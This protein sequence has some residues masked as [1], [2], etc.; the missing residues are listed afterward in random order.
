MPE[1][2][3]AADLAWRI[4]AL[5]AQRGRAVAVSPDHLLVGLLSLDKVLGPAAGLSLNKQ[6]AV[7]AEQ[8]ALTRLLADLGLDPTVLRRSIRHLAEPARRPG[9]PS[10]HRD[11]ACLAAFERAERLA[12]DRGADQCGVL[13]LLAAFL[14]Q[15]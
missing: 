6:E 7:Q 2:T 9:P 13:H 14:E 3:V 1:L 10:L 15:P 8:A 5:E 4:A 12:A 11:P